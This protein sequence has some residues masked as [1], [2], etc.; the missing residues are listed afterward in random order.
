MSLWGV[1][2]RDERDQLYI[3]ARSASTM[4]GRLTRAGIASVNPRGEK[5]HP[6]V[7]RAVSA[8]ECS[9]FTGFHP[10]LIRMQVIQ[11]DGQPTG[12]HVEGCRNMP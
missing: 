12:W 1:H 10:F 2:S 11:M 5:G 4:Q 6:G 9:Y 7:A 8:P 3:I